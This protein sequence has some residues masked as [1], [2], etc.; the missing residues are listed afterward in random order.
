MS[1]EPHRVW[2][3]KPKLHQFLH[4]TDDGGRPAKCWNYRDEDF[5]GSV[6]RQSRM[7]GRWRDISCFCRHGLDLFKMKNR[8]PRINVVDD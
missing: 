5:G 4:I 1:L 3:V 7:K 6:A 2:R 8:V